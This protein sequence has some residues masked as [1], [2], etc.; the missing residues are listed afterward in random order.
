MNP[1]MAFLGIDSATTNGSIALAEAGRIVREDRLEERARHAR[2]LLE[3]IDHLLADTGRTPGD[4]RGI[5]VAVGPGSFTGVRIGMATGKG[6]AY[7]LGIG[8]AGISTLE[9]L[10]R[11]AQPVVGAS[12]GPIRPVIDAGRGEVYAA[13]F[14]C[15]TG[16]PVR[17]DADRSWRPA[18]LAGDIGEAVVL[19]GNGTAL[20]CEAR[21]DLRRRARIIEPCPLLGGAI[22]RWVA[23]AIAPERGYQSGALRP[24]YVRPTDA[25]A[26]R[27]R[28]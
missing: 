4:L 17:A 24:N 19:V 15:D 8:L 22:A 9:A 10:A 20:L 7:A 27:R 2:D 12:S 18:D 21:P 3:R 25:E 13:L 5:G 6:M 11:A 14:R 28:I 23:C 16:E 1:A 26:T